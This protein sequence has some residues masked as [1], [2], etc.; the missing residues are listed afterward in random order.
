MLPMLYLEDSLNRTRTFL[1]LQHIQNLLAAVVLGP[2]EAAFNS[3][4][5]RPS[6][7]L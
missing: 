1:L 4:P 2:P 5:F 6:G 7:L 3:F